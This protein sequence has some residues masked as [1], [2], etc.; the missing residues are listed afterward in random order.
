MVRKILVKLLIVALLATGLTLSAFV[1]PSLTKTVQGKPVYEVLSPLAEAE[2]VPLRGISPRVETLK[3]K[4]IGLAANTKPGAD[5][6]IDVVEELLKKRF[7]TG[8]F[9][10]YEKRFGGVPRA[11]FLRWARRVDVVILSRAD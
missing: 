11:D 2:P 6:M 3:G 1:V 9:R 8:T 7:P 10:R 5:L 4:V